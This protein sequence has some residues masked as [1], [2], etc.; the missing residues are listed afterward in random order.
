MAT[1][2]KFQPRRVGSNGFRWLSAD[3]YL[4]DIDGT[5]LITRDLVH[6]NAL[7][8]AMRE[9]YGIEATIDGISYHGKTDLGILRAVLTGAGV[10]HRQF[11]DSLPAALDVVCREVTKRA[12]QILAEVCTGIPDV[13]RELQSAGKLIGVAS[14]NLET[15]GW[16]K[17]EAAGLSDFFT[18]GS[19]SDR[20]EARSVIFCSAVDEAHRRLGHHATVCF[21]GD[22]PDDV[23]AARIANAQIVSVCTGTFKAE[24]LSCHSPDVCISS[25][26]ELLR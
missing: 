20:A 5:L 3:A 14:G 25:C 1:D 16:H 23:I 6:R 26:A 18:F 17:L 19:F 15:V 13:L 8:Q 11:E 2:L 12:S 22:T 4:F 7:H 21:V 10:S 24:D 9:V